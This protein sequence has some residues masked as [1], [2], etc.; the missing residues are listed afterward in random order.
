MYPENPKIVK[1]STSLDNSIWAP[2]ESKKITNFLNNHD[3]I[4]INEKDDK[5]KENQ[6]RKL[7]MELERL[8]DNQ[9]STII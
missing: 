3:K 4:L 6:F 8:K 5:I 1:K 2:L 9:I 7:Y